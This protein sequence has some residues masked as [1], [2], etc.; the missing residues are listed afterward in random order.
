VKLVIVLT[1]IIGMGATGC[2][3]GPQTGGETH[4]MLTC[5][6]DG[7]CS[8]GQ[9]CV[10]GVCTVACTDQSE[11]DEAGLTDGACAPGDSEAVQEMCA[12]DP[13]AAAICLRPCTT[14]SPAC[15]LYEECVL[16]ASGEGFCA[17]TQPGPSCSGG[18]QCPPSSTCS[19]DEFC[20]CDPQ[21]V[22]SGDATLR[23]EP[24]GDTT[25]NCLDCSCG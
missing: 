15:D 10:C 18:Q 23:C 20:E 2:T 25:L 12:G 4:W 16:P 14:Q 17:R 5:S 11:C 3:D 13:S 21:P 19:I 9:V 6:A 8:P 22:C 7:G 24:T 1:G